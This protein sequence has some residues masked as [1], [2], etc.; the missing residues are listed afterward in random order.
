MR[1]LHSLLLGVC[2]FAAGCATPVGPTPAAD[3]HEEV[4]H[5]AVT[6][7]DRDGRVETR[8]IPVTVFRPP[9]AGPF[10]LAIVNHGRAS[11]EKR[12]AQRD[13]MR[14]ETL[15]RYLV[16]KGFAVLVPTRVGYGETYG[17]FDPE[18]PDACRTARMDVVSI[19]ASDQVL[20]TYE[21]ARTLSFVDTSPWVV[22]GVSMGG[23]ASLATAWRHPPG[24]LGGINFS[25]GTG[26][27]P[28]DFPERPCG[29]QQIASLL[30]ANAAQA[31]APMLWLYWEN[32]HYWGPEIP[33]RW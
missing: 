3:L 1:L 14:F 13:R 22:V 24:L 10:P 9:G 12:A 2:A 30:Q 17:D 11:K 23:L 25:G 26:G 4:R 28:T 16:S 31:H 15:S 5:I 19:A 29:A 6:V 33:K 21:Y 18:S 32:D 7:K 8:A 27:R 20:A